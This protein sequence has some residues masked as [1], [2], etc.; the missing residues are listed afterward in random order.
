ME[1]TNDSITEEEA[2]RQAEE[3]M[4]HFREENPGA[5][6]VPKV[7]AHYADVSSPD[8]VNAAIAEILA[9]HG[10]IDNL[11]NSAGFTENFDA[12]EYPFDRMQK[13]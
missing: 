13:L 12:I 3:L 8:S 9:E 10:K 6:R 2:V 4:N 1:P 11:V 7:T 5:E